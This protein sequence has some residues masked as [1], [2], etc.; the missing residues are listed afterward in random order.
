MLKSL[1][2]L[3]LVEREAFVRGRRRYVK[4][5]ERGRFV[6]RHAK[7]K[8][9]K[10]VRRRVDATFTLSPSTSFEDRECVDWFCKLIRTRL[11]DG[12]SVYYPW[13]PDD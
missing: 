6:L 3:G 9:R 8:T 2:A 11:G 4:L 12:A 1:E 7:R 10:H 13:H 5:T